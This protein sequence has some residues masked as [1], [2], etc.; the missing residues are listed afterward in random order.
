[1]G[2]AA[3][4]LRFAQLTARKNQVEF[5]GQQ[6]NQQRLTLSQK[7]SAIYNDMLTRQVPTAP[8]PSAFTKIVYKFNN[9]YGTSSILNL[10]KK[11]SGAYNYN[12]TYKRPKT[13]RTL[14]RSSFANV[15][16]ARTI[17]VTQISP[18]QKNN[19]V[20]YARTANVN[21]V[22]RN[23]SLVGSNTA[24]SKLTDYR[25][26]L[27]TYKNMQTIESQ[28]SA[29][30]SK[31]KNDE[32]ISPRDQQNI[33]SALGLEYNA[34]GG[35]N[36]ISRKLKSISKPDGYKEAYMSEPEMPNINKIDLDKNKYPTG[37]SLSDWNI[38]KQTAYKLCRILRNESDTIDL[39]DLTVYN[40]N[41]FLGAILGNQ[42]PGG[43]FQSPM[44]THLRKI[45]T[46]KDGEQED[47]LDSKYKFNGAANDKVTQTQI[48][49]KFESLNEL[50]KFE[51]L[52][53]IAS[54]ANTGEITSE[55]KNTQVSN[56]QHEE[57]IGNLTY[58]NNKEA[59]D[60][61]KNYGKA[62]D[63]LL[64]V[65]GGAQGEAATDITNAQ[66][67]EM[68]QGLLKAVSGGSYDTSAAYKTAQVDPAF[69]AYQAATATPGIVNIGE[70]QA[71]YEYEDDN[72]DKC[73]MYVNLTN[74]DDDEPS[75]YADSVSIYE[76]VLN[77][78]DG[79]YETEQQDANVIMSEDGQVSKITFADGSVVT[80]EVVTEMDSD[81]YDQAMVE[82]EYKKEVYDKEMNDA[83]AK[84]KIIQA[85]D[86]KL[87]VRLKQLDTEQKALQTEIDAIKS[88]R[89][90]AIE[91]SFRTF[92]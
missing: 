41:H 34:S 63:S 49:N 64:I 80:P 51:L 39:N 77:Y 28:I 8:D 74:I 11:A 78:L 42:N 25:Q 15:G 48:R 52:N 38:K 73:Y 18:D 31:G 62:V 12:V 60:N 69:T 24:A 44:S 50:E 71:L 61:Y 84:V 36:E 35:T 20:Y 70:N 19:A 57:Y 17:G 67:I 76:N 81:A 47:A 21:G 68:L 91:S 58:Q 65:S 75:T 2:M 46:G 66:M 85:Q 82:Y 37:D 33:K 30:V 22:A 23:L 72:G 5:E 14:S 86:Q 3:S 26:K 16:F 79:E 10:A 9:G 27:E 13:T 1:M 29:L 90:K 4:S 59:W 55:L 83:N 92:S 87:E 7:S 53:L 32:V 56:E 89:D 40:V 88:V 54:Y 45:L 6:I 43:D